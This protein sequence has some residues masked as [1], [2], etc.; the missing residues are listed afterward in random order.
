MSRRSASQKA[1]EQILCKRGTDKDLQAFKRLFPSSEALEVWE[2]TYIHNVVLGI[3]PLS[4][5]LELQKQ[6]YRDQINMVDSTGRTPLHW[7]TMRGEEEAVRC[8]LDAGADAN[9]QDDLKSTPLSL[10]ASSGSVRMLELLIL[11]GADVDTRNNIGSQAIHYASR[12]RNDVE[13]V[14]VLLRAGA[15]VNSGNN[16]GH[17][18]LSGA[19]ITNR[20]RIGAHLLEHGADVNIFSIHGDTPLFET[21]MHNSHEFLKML[22]DKGVCHT[23]VNAAGST[24]FHVAALEADVRTLEILRT[25]GLSGVNVD[26]R[27]RNGKTALEISRLRRAAPDGFG[28]AF[29]KLVASTSCE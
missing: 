21:V 24:L 17:T 27:D 3:L 26:A 16:F 20:H 28:E 8:L 12:H 19:A 29:E 10:A 22:I 23:H 9:V 2:F 6:Q 18:P 11:A 5:M 4:I 14:A 15:S 13:P 7:A 25:A 1:W